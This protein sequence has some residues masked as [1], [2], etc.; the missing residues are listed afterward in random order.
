MNEKT[1]D[2]HTTHNGLG[3]CRG[4]SGAS[5]GKHARSENAHKAGADI[6]VVEH[7][8]NLVASKR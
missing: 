7:A 8:L 5:Q 1:N 6:N 3:R 2:D 4:V